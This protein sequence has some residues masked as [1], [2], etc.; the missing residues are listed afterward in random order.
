MPELTQREKLQ[1]RRLQQRIFSI[2]QPY[3]YMKVDILAT[4]APTFMFTEGKLI[5]VR[6]TPQIEE[7][8]AEID[9]LCKID[10]LQAIVDARIPAAVGSIIA[11]SHDT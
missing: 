10:M 1:L 7:Q 9:R 5:E 2:M 4:A 8:L 6:Y 3:V 11:L